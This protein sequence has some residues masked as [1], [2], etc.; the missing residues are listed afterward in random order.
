MSLLIS[1][2]DAESLSKLLRQ[3]RLARSTS[4]SL[5]F[6]PLP[7]K[8]TAIAVIVSKKVAKSAVE[9]NKL[10]RRGRELLRAAAPLSPRPHALV[11]TFHEPAS[12]KTFK[13]LRGELI[14]VLS[15]HGIAEVP[16]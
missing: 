8:K 13:E 9:R 7:G 3:G 15:S 11:L 16:T 2:L 4:F 6:S 10:K 12:K 5:R 14:T 1:R